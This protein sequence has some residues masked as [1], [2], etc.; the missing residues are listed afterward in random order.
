VGAA[1]GARVETGGLGEGILAEGLDLRPGQEPPL[2]REEVAEGEL[3]NGDPLELMDLVAEL[4]EHAADLAIL[5]L[6]ENHLED[7]ALLVLG[8]EVDVLGAGH[9]LG[10]ADA[11]TEFVERFR[12]GDSRHLDEIFLLDAIPR[13]GEEIGQF[14]VVG[15]EDQPFAHPVEPADGE[16]PLL[17]GY[18]VDDAGPAVRIE[19]RGHH[20]DRLG[21]HVDHPLRVGEPLAVDADLL[22]ER[23][24]PGAEL[25]HHL[26]VDL[27]PPGRD[28][29]FA[30][31]P[32]AEA[33]CRE[34][35]LKP[36]QAVIDGDGG[37]AEAAAGRL[38]GRLFPD[39]PTGW[40]GTARRDP[41]ATAPIGLP[42]TTRL[43]GF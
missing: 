30:V 43:V 36:L 7:R 29:L 42:G 5:P 21:E 20:A 41:R 22:T 31:P 24:D 10:E 13:M 11:A 33:C 15:N 32:A 23:I 3:S 25:R 1:R 2:S 39:R 17:P 8:L 12:S 40:R 37:L 18:E 27:D 4:R 14:A 16:Q 19:V 26:A 28:Q 9:S 35:L 34:H 38:G 6:V